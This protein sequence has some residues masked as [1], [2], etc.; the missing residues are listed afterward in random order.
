MEVH[1]QGPEIPARRRSN[2]HNRNSSR[3]VKLGFEIQAI[4]HNNVITHLEFFFCPLTSS[5]KTDF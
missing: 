3:Q 2:L 1:S 5:L 4:S